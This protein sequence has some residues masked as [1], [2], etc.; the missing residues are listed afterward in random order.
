MSDFSNPIVQEARGIIV[1]ENDFKVVCFP[2]T[3]FFNV[4][5]ENAAEEMVVNDINTKLPDVILLSMDSTRQEEWLVNNRGKLNAK[6]CLAVGSIM[7]HILRDNVHVPLWIRKLHCA[8]LFRFLV[9]IPNS[10]FFRK[11]IF[12]RKMDDY[13]TKKKLRG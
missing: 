5:E 2:F 11:R 12:N 7:P 9:Q 6:L 4:D 10:K 1:R 13:N 8:G 3:K